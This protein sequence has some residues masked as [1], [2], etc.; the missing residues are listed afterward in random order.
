VSMVIGGGSFCSPT[1]GSN[2]LTFGL[3]RG[4]HSSPVLMGTVIKTIA[5]AGGEEISRSQLLGKT[6]CFGG[7]G[8]GNSRF[9]LIWP[10][11]IPSV[12]TTVLTLPVESVG[13]LQWRFAPRVWGANLILL[14]GRTKFRPTLFCQGVCKILQRGCVKFEAGGA[15]NFQQGLQVCNSPL[16]WEGFSGCNDTNVDQR[17]QR[18]QRYPRFLAFLLCWTAPEV[19]GF[20]RF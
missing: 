4:E 20:C 13:Q 5:I 15:G 3:V 9:P 6:W 11:G 18:Y 14:M 16:A 7:K 10:P 17:Y 19:S 8:G 2:Y 1:S 12:K